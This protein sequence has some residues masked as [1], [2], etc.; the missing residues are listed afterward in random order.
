MVGRHLLQRIFGTLVLAAENPREAHALVDRA[1][2]TLGW[3]DACAFCSIMLAVPATIA[4]AQVGDLPG[5][6]RHLELARQSVALWQGTSWEAGL[7]EA[8]AA[9]AAA[10]GDVV[11]A[12]RRLREAVEIFERTGQPRDAERCRTALALARR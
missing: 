5:A 8:E 11:T 10:T 4:C 12:G 6:E 7:A 3:D 1:D 2:A 9:V